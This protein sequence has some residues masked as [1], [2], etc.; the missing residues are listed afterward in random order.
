VHGLE[1]EHRLHNLSAFTRNPARSEE[2]LNAEEEGISRFLS[3]NEIY[4]DEL[5]GEGMEII[6]MELERLM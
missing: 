1:L 6:S 4:W 5:A 3:A 2:L